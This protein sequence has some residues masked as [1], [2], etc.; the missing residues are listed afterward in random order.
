MRF[1]MRNLMKT[2][3]SMDGETFSGLSIWLQMGKWTIS[4]LFVTHSGR[5][6]M[7]SLSLQPVFMRKL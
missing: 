2:T 1:L 4:V 5:E 7:Q 3:K 6:M